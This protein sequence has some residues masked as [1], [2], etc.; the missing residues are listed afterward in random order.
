M[1]L[2]S[3]DLTSFWRRDG[4]P[5]AGR[6]SSVFEQMSHSVSSEKEPKAPSVPLAST[7][8][9]NAIAVIA[10]AA[11]SIQIGVETDGPVRSKDIE[12]RLLYFIFEA[13]FALFFFL[14]MLVRQ[15]HHGW[16]YF[17]Y[18]WNF[19]ITVS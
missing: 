10:I 17:L 2:A 6:F 8:Y 19:S 5:V 9:F 18:P 3:L 12:D 4:K 16:D 1:A 11:N 13:L 15:H 14:E 7:T